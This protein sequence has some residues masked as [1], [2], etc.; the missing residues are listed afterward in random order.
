MSIIKMSVSGVLLTAVVFLSG[1]TIGTSGTAGKT[2][3]GGV[4]RSDDGGKAW[5]QKVVVP[6]ATGKPASIAGVQI[7]RLVFDP[8]DYNAIYAVTENDGIIY[9]Y[10]G[11]TS[12]KSISG[13]SRAGARS[14]AIDPKDKCTLYATV[15]NRLY[16]SVDCGRSWENPYWHPNNL[17]VLTDV[18]VDYNNSAIIYLVTSTGEILKSNNRGISWEQLYQTNGSFVDIIINS[19]DSKVIYAATAKNGI[20]KTVDAGKT[21]VSPDVG[22]KAYSNTNE[23]KALLIDRNSPNIIFLV[24]SYSIFK[25]IDAGSTW[26]QIKLLP[27]QK[28]VAIY[29]AALNPKN[30]NEIYYTTK[31]AFLKSSD[32]G[33]TW[34]SVKLP[35]TRVAN[36][37]L[38]NPAMPSTIYLGAYTVAK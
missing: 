18:A 38:I 37:I 3:D 15:A 25:S 7:R 11:A 30:S 13:I 34:L 17:T 6:T 29:S 2:A 16:K 9:S 21:W 35:F 19:K 36:R 14:I 22:L 33:T 10:D 20:Y 32:G 8:Q 1:C 24:T 4:W 12:W 31:T 5:A 27:G 28:A 26:A 23:Y